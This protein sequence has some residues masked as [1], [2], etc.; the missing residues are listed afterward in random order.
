MV[1]KL[2]LPL[3]LACGA[4]AVVGACAFG[5][6]GATRRSTGRS[7]LILDDDIGSDMVVLEREGRGQ[8][9]THENGRVHVAYSA[10]PRR[11]GSFPATKE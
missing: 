7:Q 4:V 11:D 9:L 10:R 8:V 6:A 2:R 5:P 1:P 3:P